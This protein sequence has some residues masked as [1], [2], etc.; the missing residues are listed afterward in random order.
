MR[1]GNAAP[2]VY[3]SLIGQIKRKTDK[4]VLLIVHDQEGNPVVIN[5]KAVEEW[6]PISQ[7][8]SIHE[9]YDEIEGTFDVLMLPEWILTK[10]NVLRYSGA[11]G[12]NPVTSVNVVKPKTTPAY[13][14][15]TKKDHANR[16]PYKDDEG[17][18]FSDMDDD[19][20]F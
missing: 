11:A 9:G 14:G 7:C 20:P 19:I 4:A 2:N 6:F 10:N 8:S 1:H 13:T 3:R 16:M 17:P 12:V 15:I 5:D 18:L